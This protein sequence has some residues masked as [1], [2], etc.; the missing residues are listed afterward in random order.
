MTKCTGLVQ[1]PNPKR[2]CISAK[3]TAKWK[4]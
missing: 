4:N 1:I 2:I 3:A